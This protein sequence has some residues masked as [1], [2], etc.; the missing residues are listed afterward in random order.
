MLCAVQHENR[1]FCSPNVDSAVP[2]GSFPSTRSRRPTSAVDGS[3]GCVW[4][5]VSCGFPCVP[6]WIAQQSF[7]FA[8]YYSLPAPALNLLASWK[9]TAEGNLKAVQRAKIKL[10][11][12]ER[13]NAT[14]SPN[15]PELPVFSCSSTTGSRSCTL[16][17]SYILMSIKSLFTELTRLRP[18]HP[19]CFD[20]ITIVHQLPFFLSLPSPSL[21]LPL[22]LSSI[23]PSGF[24]LLRNAI[25]S[26]DVD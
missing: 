15:E 26:S 21:Y 22:F 10:E 12:R 24:C 19:P 8:L 5:P 13:R 16:V 4:V 2:T 25:V 7:T 17:F 3:S 6:S 1:L 23:K 18:K 9:K 20:H 14:S 11:F